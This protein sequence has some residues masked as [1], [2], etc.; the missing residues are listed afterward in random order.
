[1]LQA[2]N[3]LIVVTG[4]SSG[5]GLELAKELNQQGYPLLLLARRIEILNSLK[6]KNTLC[7]KVDVSNLTSLQEAIQE[8]EKHFNLPVDCLVNNAGVMLLGHLDKQNPQEWQQMFNVNV[9]GILHGIHA[10][11]P[12]MKTRKHGT[13]INISSL[14]GRKIYDGAAAYCG[15]KVAVHTLSEGLR[16]ELAPFNI[17]VITIAPGVAQTELLNHTTSKEMLALRQEE[18]K[19]ME[20]TMHAKDVV[21]AI[22]FAYQQPQEICIREID[23]AATCQLR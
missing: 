23:L 2:H 22:L 1:M 8:A 19:N 13:I 7:K 17:R 11:T 10:V 18:A 4:A 21:K 15:T 16:T 9:L 14:A 3:K 5:F 12:S 6:L 20:Y